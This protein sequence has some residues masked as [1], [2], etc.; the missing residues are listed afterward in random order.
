MDITKLI[1]GRIETG[2]VIGAVLIIAFFIISTG[3]L[4]LGS[5]PSV[6]R[7]T[8]G[9]GIIAIGQAIL[10]TSGEVD[11]SVGSVFAFVGV[12]FIWCMDTMAIGV[13]PSALLALVVACAIGFLNGVL[14]TRFGVPSMIVTLGGLF[15]YRGITYIATRG[16]SMSIPREYRRDGVVELLKSRIGDVNVTVIFLLVLTAFFVF[17]LAKTRFGNHLLAVGG[18]PRAALANGISPA[19]TKIKSFMVCS[20]LAG[21][22]GVLVV[23]QEGSVY[24]TSGVKMELE[25]IAAAVI[26]G[27]T[28]RG[29]VG[30]IWGPVLGVF[31]LSSLKGGLMMMGAPTSWYI[32]L[33]G[34]ILIG[35]LMF[36][37]L[38]DTRLGAR[39]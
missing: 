13:I 5:I 24:S 32:A 1:L 7:I 36:S 9:V 37:R 38:L 18:N 10:M 15:V 27:C 6:L 33:V 29:G 34:A 3:G 25:T 8:A 2:V 4:W 30:S 28:L 11:L 21:L 23:C 31:V 39:A 16:F 26:G 20:G 22:A 14:T 12:V 35:F 19:A 17:V